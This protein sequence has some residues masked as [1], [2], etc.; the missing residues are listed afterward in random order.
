[1]RALAISPPG[2]AALRDWLGTARWSAVVAQG[3]PGG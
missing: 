3:S 2:A 1:M